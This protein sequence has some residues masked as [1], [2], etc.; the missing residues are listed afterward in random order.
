M[1]NASAGLVAS[2]V[3]VEDGGKLGKV[4]P[5]GLAH[6][7]QLLTGERRTVFRHDFS[8]LVLSRHTLSACLASASF[9]LKL[10]QAQWQLTPAH[11]GPQC[12]LVRLK[13]GSGRGFE[14][15]VIQPLIAG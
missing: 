5:V 12:L 13:C 6:F 14:I 9:S 1:I 7:D 11:K 15:R 4:F 3:R 2:G 10:L 8:P